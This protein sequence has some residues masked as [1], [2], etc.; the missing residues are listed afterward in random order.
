MK[1]ISK[2]VYQ[3]LKRKH[4]NLKEANRLGLTLN[5]YKA[6]KRRVLDVLNEKR[7]LTEE[8]FQEIDNSLHLLKSI[9]HKLTE[10]HHNV[11]KGTSKLTA[12]S[13]TEPKTPEEIIKLLGIDTTK[14]KLSQFWNKEQ[15]SKWL[16]SALITRLP[17][18]QVIE[19]SFLDQLS[20]YEL[21]IYDKINPMYLIN[22]SSEK[23]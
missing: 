7:I 12:I 18:Q 11:E 14:W 22:S 15:N 23:V 4:S 1:L 6:F 2:L 20:K 9:S 16:V 13:S 17:E 10:T 3:G 8:D 21:P 19:Q 5:E